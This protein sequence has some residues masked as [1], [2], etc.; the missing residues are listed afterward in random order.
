MLA[1]RAERWDGEN[2]PHPMKGAAS[3][4]LSPTKWRRAAVRGLGRQRGLW[5]KFSLLCSAL[6]RSRRRLSPFIASHIVI[7]NGDSGLYAAFDCFRGQMM[8]RQPP[9]HR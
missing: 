8:R 4:L 6:I 2:P 1:Q 5:G 9:P 3:H 7:L